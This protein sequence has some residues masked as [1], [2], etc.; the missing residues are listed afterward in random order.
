[1]IRVKLGPGDHPFIRKPTV[2]FYPDTRLMPVETIINE[3]KNGQASF[4]TDCS[5]AL[6]ELVRQGLLTSPATPRRL[7]AYV[8]E[9]I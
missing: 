6:L 1:M 9:R 5:E 8:R 3:V 4:H 2:V 7:K